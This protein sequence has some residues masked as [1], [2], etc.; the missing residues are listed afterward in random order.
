MGSIKAN[1]ISHWL[2][3][4]NAFSKKLKLGIKK[5]NLEVT[6]LEATIHDIP[7]SKIHYNLI[8][9]SFDKDFLKWQRWHVQWLSHHLNTNGFLFVLAPIFPSFNSGVVLFFKNIFHWFLWRITLLSQLK[10]LKRKL[11]SAHFRAVLKAYGIVEDQFPN[12]MLFLK[13]EGFIFKKYQKSEIL[14]KR[15]L[16]KASFLTEELE[17]K[18][19][20]RL[21]KSTSINKKL[22]KLEKDYK[23]VLVLAPH[24]D[25]ELVGCGGT[26]LKLASLGAEIHIIQMTEGVTSKGLFYEAGSEKRKIRWEEARRVANVFNFKQYYWKTGPDTKLKNSSKEQARL[27]DLMDEIK[28]DLIFVPARTD[29]HEE[30][31]LAFAIYYE[32]I[33][34]KNFIVNPLM[35]SYPVWGA[36]HEITHFAEVNEFSNQVL[37]AMYLYETAMRP[38]DYNK[39]I[40]AI[41]AYQ[42]Q[43]LSKDSAKETEVFSEYNAN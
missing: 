33:K 25:D 29:L 30:H 38:Q 2:N 27:N 39:R 12:E 5:S 35:L 31:C 43:L 36:L 22:I 42:G 34:N 14:Y 7:K 28:P 23:K 9:L 4:S 8:C 10:F 24:P 6:L 17:K 37:E 26:L 1:N 20:D 32:V 40:L 3:L 21:I 16:Q 18:Y 13:R 15:E 41:W 19:S 11:F